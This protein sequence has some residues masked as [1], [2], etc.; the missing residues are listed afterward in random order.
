MKRF[1]SI[2]LAVLLMS[3]LASCGDSKEEMENKAP[4]SAPAEAENYDT[5]DASL[6]N[7]RNQDEIEADELDR[8][9]VV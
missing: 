8:K 2:L 5:G 4:V 3:L 9:S 7:P 6:D 1:L